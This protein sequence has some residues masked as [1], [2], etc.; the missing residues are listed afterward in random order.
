V[1]C[2]VAYYRLYHVRRGRFARSNELDADDDVAAVRQAR[3]LVEDDPAELWCGGR[4][5]STFNEFET[6]S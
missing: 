6:P 4:K 5:V 2:S 1:A 3:T